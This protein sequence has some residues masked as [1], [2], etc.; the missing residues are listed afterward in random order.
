[1]MTLIMKSHGLFPFLCGAAALLFF[2]AACN[3]A[4]LMAAA[5]E[6]GPGRTRRHNARRAQGGVYA[7]APKF[8]WVVMQWVPRRIGHD[9][10][11]N[12][13]HGH[14]DGKEDGTPTHHARQH[15]Q[16]RRL[17]PRRL[18]VRVVHKPNRCVQH[19]VFL[20]LVVAGHAPSLLVR[21]SPAEGEADPRLRLQARA[22]T[23]K[24]GNKKN[25]EAA[26]RSRSRG[27][28]GHAGLAQVR[29]G[30]GCKDT[31][32]MLSCAGSGCFFRSLSHIQARPLSH[33]RLRF[34]ALRE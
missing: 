28:V 33:R 23:R 13:H 34:R 26:V 15:L 29:E 14:D 25:R 18:I 5:L 22:K 17:Q 1:M 4:C 20:V 10:P 31:A 11:H 9:G 24:R 7:H 6:L 8:T 16:P 27:C 32:C 30:G 2:A 3:A 12:G 21:T 19:L